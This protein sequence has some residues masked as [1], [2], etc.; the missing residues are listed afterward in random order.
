MYTIASHSHLLKL[1]QLFKLLSC[2]TQ[3]PF[4][5]HYANIY[6][7]T[8]SIVMVS[9]LGL[10]LFNFYI[11]HVGNKIFNNSTIYTHTISM[12]YSW[13]KPLRII[14]SYS[15]LTNSNINNKIPFLVILVDANS[16]NFTTSLYKNLLAE[17]HVY[18]VTKVYV[19]KDT[20]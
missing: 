3:V 2:L 16:H 8:D 17:T 18:L 13:K 10:T 20:K 19:L 5:N 11:F 15:L 4:Y 12:T 14:L 1:D 9:A 7:Q 6:A